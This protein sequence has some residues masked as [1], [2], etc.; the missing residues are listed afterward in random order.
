MS[1][2]PLKI[3]ILGLG[4]VGA[5]TVKVLQDNEAII[6]ARAGRKIEVVLGATKTPENVKHLGI[7]VSSDVN[8]VLNNPE[9]EVIVELMGGVDFAYECVKTALLNGKSVVTANKAMLAYHRSE[10]EGLAKNLHFGYEA[11]VAGGI[12]VIYALRDGLPANHIL[13]IKGIINGTCNYILTRMMKEGAGFED[14]LAEAQK[15]GYAEADPT[16]DVGG[17]DTAHKLLILASIAYGIDAKPDDILIEGIAEISAD[18]IDFAKEYDLTIKLLAIAKKH[19]NHTVEL[20]VHPTMISSEHILADVEGVMNGVAIVGDKVGETMFYG[21]G[22]GGD[23]TASSVV[24][25]LIEIARSESA[26][27]MLGFNQPLEKDLTLRAKGNISSKYYM[28]IR[29]KDETGVLA[30]IAG[31]LSANSVSIENFMQKPKNENAL[32]LISTHVAQEEDIQKAVNEIAQLSCV[33][34][35]PFTMRLD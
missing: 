30:K 24:A 20:R 10:L 8:D 2:K 4:V 14:V 34:A 3:G 28:R 5:A 15:L 29:A 6:T 35:K 13:S 17:F 23:A 26:T 16:A 32:L 18:D 25:N 27:A 12:P 22:A 1:K 9:V 19:D 31:I 21:A 7:K 11:S 33:V